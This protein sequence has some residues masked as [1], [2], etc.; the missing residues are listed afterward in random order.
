MLEDCAVKV[1]CTV[2]SD[3]VPGKVVIDAG[4]KTLSSDRNIPAPESGYGYVIG[5]SEAKIT[6][7]SEEHGEIDMQFCAARPKVGQRICVIPNHVCPCINLHDTV[8]LSSADH[9]LLQPICVDARG[10]LS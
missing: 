9:E 4:T 7:L 8:W 6:R 10:E 3:A 1:C 5:W 2:V